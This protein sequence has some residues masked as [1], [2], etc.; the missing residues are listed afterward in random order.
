MTH[1]LCTLNMTE[2]DESECEVVEEG[3]ILDVW[4]PYNIPRSV[5]IEKQRIIL[6]FLA[7]VKGKE[8]SNDET[9]H[10][11][12][13]G[14]WLETQMGIL[15]NARNEP[16][17]MGYEMKKT[18]SKI[19]LGDF[20]A[21]EYL[22][23][24]KKET[25]EHV[26]QWRTNQYRFTRTEFIR[27]FGTPKPSKNNRYSW[28]GSCVPTYGEWNDCGQRL[29]F[30]E[31]LDLCVHYSFEKDTRECKYDFPTCV[32]T[33]VLIAI[34]K[35]TKLEAHI[36]KKFNVKGFFICKKVHHTYEKICFGRPFDFMYFVNHIKNKTIIFDSGMYEGNSRNYS[37][38]RSLLNG[39]WQNLI[40]E[41][42]P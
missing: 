5:D 15:H 12:S 9:T 1:V 4:N 30:N 36:N 41:E 21:S 38:F 17:I 37:Q 23:S 18:S 22:F 19:T 40:T 6:T 13:E 24:R 10:C 20:S 2:Y 35:R 8:Y 26:N 14:H 33:D 11:G 25:I 16:D 3:S 29:V 42:Y 7:N 39:F 34:W 28:S 27:Y 31:Q 32:Q